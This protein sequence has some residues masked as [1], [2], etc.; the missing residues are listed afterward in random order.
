MP[1]II[2]VNPN[3]ALSFREHLG[4]IRETLRAGGIIAFPTDTFYGLGADPFNSTA[5]EKI[6]RI[7]ARSEDKPLLVLAASL[8]QAAGLYTR[9][10]PEAQIL[11]EHFWPGPLTLLLEASTDLPRPLTGG[12][13]KI[14]LRIP[15]NELTRKLL[16]DLGFSLTAP[17]A[18]LSGAESPKTAE[19]VARS[20]GEH[21]D[22]IV[23]GGTTLGG[24]PST[25]LDTTVSP[26]AIIREGAVPW[27]L[28]SSALKFPGI[29]V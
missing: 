4:T 5:L 11:I 1:T 6:Y 3:D 13:H 22:L 7:K 9:I 14:G 25:L 20:I 8:E 18:N 12:S 26:P 19:D 23:D 28:I 21:V 15:G 29:S 17:S 10:S 16:L 2:R 24:K 27:S